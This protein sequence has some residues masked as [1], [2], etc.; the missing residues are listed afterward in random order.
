[1]SVGIIHYAP[2]ATREDSLLH[3]VRRIELP[4]VSLIQ[5]TGSTHQI[6]RI[7]IAIV[8]YNLLAV[9]IELRREALRR[10][11]LALLIGYLYT[12]GHNSNHTLTL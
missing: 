6:L 1:M 9:H 10:E 5:R 4:A 12:V 7:L 2:T 8:P 3:R 11:A